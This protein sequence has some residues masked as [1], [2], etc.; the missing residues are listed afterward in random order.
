MIAR[1]LTALCLCI[2]LPGPLQAACLGK[3]T[4][5][6]GDS[7]SCGLHPYYEKHSYGGGAPAGGGGGTPDPDPEP[8]PEPEPEPS[9]P[10][11]DEPT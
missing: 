11:E 6:F 9:P 4:G 3:D 7:G 1:I 8:E 5:D 2:L 10:G